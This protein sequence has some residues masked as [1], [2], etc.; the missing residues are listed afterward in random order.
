MEVATLIID[1]ADFR[2][3]K[4]RDKEKYYIKIKGVNLQSR[5]LCEAKIDE[6]QGE[7]HESTTITED[8]NIPLSVTDRSRRQEIRKDTGELTVRSTGPNSHL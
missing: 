1:K 4:L 8:F 5:K 7:I 3:S 2:A 6:L